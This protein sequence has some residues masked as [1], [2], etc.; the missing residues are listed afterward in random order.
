[1]AADL[2]HTSIKTAIAERHA[3]AVTRLWLLP[4]RPAPSGRPADEVEDAITG[5]LAHAV[6]QAAHPRSRPVHAMVSVA[7]YLSAG[8]PADDGTACTDAWR[9]G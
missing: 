5:A 7:S 6:T 1:V 9:T 2:G 8:V 4:A 3:T